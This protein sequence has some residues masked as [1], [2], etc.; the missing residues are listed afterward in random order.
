MVFELYLGIALFL[1]LVFGDPRWYP[2]P[3]KIIG[4]ASLWFEE[5]FRKVLRS[6]KIAGIATTTATLLVSIGVLVILF[7]IAMSFGE[8]IE[9]I[10]AILLLYSLIAVKDLVRHSR[11]VYIA[12]YP[13]ENINEARMA[14]SQIVGRDT[15]AMTSTEISRACV[16]TVAENMV[17]GITAPLFYAVLFSFFSVYVPF[18]DIAMAAIG[19]LAYKTVNTMDSMFGYKNSRYLEFGWAPARLD[20]LVNFVPARLSGLTV[21]L[22]AFLLKYNSRSS[23]KVFLRDRLNHAS[24]NAGHTEAALAGAFGIQLGGPSTYFGNLVNKPFVGDPERKISAD[25][26]LAANRLILVSAGIFLFFCL[27]LRFIFI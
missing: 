13:S 16:E 6:P 7:K 11:E 21:V 10:L 18:S 20:D 4:K 1:D 19:M 2:H 24:P 23:L 5:Y 22:G 15:A 9:I 27:F 8:A 14:V 12:L 17:D 3:V 26:I 25:S